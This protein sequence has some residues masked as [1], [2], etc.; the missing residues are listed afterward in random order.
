MQGQDGVRVLLLGRHPVE[1]DELEVVELPLGQPVVE[2]LHD[3]PRPVAHADHHDA[4]RHVG[5]FHDGL[6]GGPVLVHLPVGDDDEDVVGLHL[7]HDVYRL[8]DDGREV[9]GPAQANPGGHPLVTVQHLREAEAPARVP[10]E[11]EDAVAVC[12]LVGEAE[13]RDVAVQVEGLEGAAHDGDDPLVGVE[14]L[15]RH[16][17]V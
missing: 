5:S 15:A 8:A 16:H 1:V 3:V 13:G 14:H 11:G 17:A 6:D 10:G 9:R 7:L 4:E 12:L 2:V